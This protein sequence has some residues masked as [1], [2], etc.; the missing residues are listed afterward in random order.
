MVKKKSEG[1]RRAGIWRAIESLGGKSSKKTGSIGILFAAVK[2][3]KE[4]GAVRLAKSEERV[5]R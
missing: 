2:G 5:A 3:G 4:G 1:E